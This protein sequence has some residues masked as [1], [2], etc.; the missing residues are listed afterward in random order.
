MDITFKQCTQE[1]LCALHD[2]SCKTFCETF[3]GQNTEADLQ[4]YLDRASNMEKLR[5]ELQNASSAFYFVYLGDALA[6]YIKLNEAPAQT[7][8]HDE[9][10]LEIERIYIAREFQGHGLGRKLIERAIELARTGGKQYIWL[11]VWE[12]NEKAIGFY[13]KHGFYRIGAHTFLVGS[14]EQ[15]DYLL[16]RD[17]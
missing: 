13:Q 6:G 10:A 7:E 8:I 3:A 11:G 9:N 17:L 2:L 5:A 14:D 4:A 16:R 15:T 1:A 12:K